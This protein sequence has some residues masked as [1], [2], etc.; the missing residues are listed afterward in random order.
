MIS[1]ERPPVHIKR[2]KDVPFRII[3]ELTIR[4]VG[5]KLAGVF[6]AFCRRAGPINQWLY[7]FFGNRVCIWKLVG[8][9]MCL[10]APRFHWC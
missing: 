6:F 3:R 5:S 10:E 8:G 2:R 1:W 7:F 4:T 9:G